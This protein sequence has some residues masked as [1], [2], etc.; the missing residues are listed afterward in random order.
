MDNIVGIARNQ[1]KWDLQ[2]E[3]LTDPDD[4][5]RMHDTEIT[6]EKQRESGWTGTFY[7]DFDPRR[8]TYKES[9][10]RTQARPKPEPKKSWATKKDW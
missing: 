1:E 6:V 2:K 8:L 3:G 9:K 5:N 4:L 7:L 10:S